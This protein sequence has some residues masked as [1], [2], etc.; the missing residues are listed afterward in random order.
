MHAAGT[1]LAAV[2]VNDARDERRLAHARVHPERAGRTAIHLPFAARLV[3]VLAPRVAL[4]RDRT[5]RD[6]IETCKC[7][8]PNQSI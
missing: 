1:H 5:C 3:F 8:A 2:V 4:H 6:R 7:T